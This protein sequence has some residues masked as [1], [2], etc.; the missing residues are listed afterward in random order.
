MKLSSSLALG[1]AVS[2]M[3]FTAT[4]ADKP[5]IMFI[6]SDDHAAHAI[7]A[8]GGRLAPLNPTPT[9]DQLA[10]EGLRYSHAY[11]TNS[12]CTPSRA[13]IMTGQYSKTNGILDLG[14]RLPKEKQFLAIEMKKAGY[15]TAMVGK[16]HL[17][18]EPN[19]DFYQVL[20]G[21]G[22]YHNPDFRI[23]GT[24]PW[25]RNMVKMKGHSSD[26]ITDITLD[27]LKNKRDKTKP[28][29]MMHHYK[30]PHDMFDNAKRYESYLKDVKVPE[31]ASMY[32][33]GNNGSVATRGPN[34]S[35]RKKIGTSISDR[36][37]KRNYVKKWAKGMTGKEATSQAYQTYMKK[38]LRCVKGVDDNLKR[39]FGYMKAEGL[40]DNT[41]I[42]YTGDQGFMLGEH[43]YMDKRWMYEES[44]QMPFI[45]RYPKLVKAGRV[46]D[47]L[48]NNTDY[49]PTMLEL[50]G[51]PVPDYMQGKSFANDVKGKD[52]GTWREGTYYRY[53]MH[54]AHHWNPAHFGIRTKKFKLIFFYGHLAKYSKSKNPEHKPTPPGWELYDMEKDPKEMNNLYTNP[55][56]K[57]VIAKLKEQLKVLREELNETDIDD[58]KIQAIIDK[59]WND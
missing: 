55:E 41:I 6:M 5:N 54:M 25:P 8:Y 57:P 38:Y 7:G 4:A 11:C 48:V 40:M 58:P 49:A 52:I 20:P 27:W 34:D 33:P 18:L 46:S 50:A 44:M 14:G 21:Q 12:I 13:C 1:V 30:A 9:L 39:L 19:F 43:D 16:W 28:F 24:K 3:A 23:Q 15:Q 56:Y 35:L 32:D 45:V 10:K 22:K 2:A 53:W 17:K 47:L 51:I 26:A 42:M 36:H 29:F 59:H 37:F 31:P